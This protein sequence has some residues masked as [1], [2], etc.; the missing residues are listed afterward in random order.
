MVD[1]AETYDEQTRAHIPDL[2]RGNEKVRAE[3]DRL[4]AERNLHDVSK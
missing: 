4:K 3:R 1:Q 2:E